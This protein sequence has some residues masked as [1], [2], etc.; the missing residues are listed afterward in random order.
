MG[1]ALLFAVAAGVLLLLGAV[2]MAIGLSRPPRFTYATALA[3]RLPTSPQDLQLPAREVVVRLSDATTTPAWVIEPPTPDPADP[4]RGRR[5]PHAPASRPLSL[6]ITHGWGDGRHGLLPLAVRLLPHF[7]QVVLYDLRAHGDSTAR[8]SRLGRVEPDDLAQVLRQTLPADDHDA[9][10]RS[11]D[12]V[13]MGLSMGAGISIDTAVRGPSD[14]RRRIAA[15]IAEGTSLNGTQPLIG[16][17]QHNRI[18]ARPLAWLTSFLLALANLPRPTVPRTDRL[19][20]RLDR[21]LLLLHGG[22]DPICPV[23]SARRIAAASPHARLVE[24]DDAAHL[25]LVARQPE[26][27]LEA[28]C[29]LLG[30]L[31]HGPADRPAP[32]AGGLAASVGVPAV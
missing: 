6:V 28:V 8:L 3:R 23:A 18:P 24:F 20:A 31:S 5:P 7:Q 15:V 12:V 14:V 19:A 2:A 25:D 11:P 32:D 13:L 29:G 21:P 16:F 22:R 17:L 10:P 4:R 26:R 30:R 9:A 27:Y 1:L